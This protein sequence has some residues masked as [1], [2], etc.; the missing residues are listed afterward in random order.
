[1]KKSNIFYLFL[2]FLCSS[3]FEV[4]AGWGRGGR[5]HRYGGHY[6][7]GRNYR[8]YYYGDYYDYG[9]RFCSGVRFSFGF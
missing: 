5:S 3:L 2:F 8:P 7:Y 4:E 6:G 9:P 1:M